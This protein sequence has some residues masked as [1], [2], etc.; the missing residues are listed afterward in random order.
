MTQALTHDSQDVQRLDDAA[1]RRAL[2]GAV[3]THAG[4][5]LLVSSNGV[6]TRVE[7]HLHHLDERQLTIDLNSDSVEVSSL[8]PITAVQGTFEGTGGPFVFE[9]T[10]ASS[11]CGSHRRRLVL[12]RPFQLARLERRRSRRTPLRDPAPVGIHA[13]TNHGSWQCAAA[14]L[15]LSPEG[16]SCRVRESDAAILTQA[17]QLRCQFRVGELPQAFDLICRITHVTQGGTPGHAVLGV[18]FGSAGN[19]SDTSDRLRA[20][21]AAV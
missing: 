7:G 12:R 15:T 2:E 18:A 1:S 17:R 9:A 21:L 6:E 8:L 3:R 10:P 13:E 16:M 11:P 19:P 5:R 14:M 20:A 4:L